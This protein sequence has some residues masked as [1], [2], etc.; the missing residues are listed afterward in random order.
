MPKPR[1]GRPHLRE[2]QR[3]Q[4]EIRFELPEDA[5]PPEHPARLLWEV[6]GR[7]DLGAF[8]AGVTS[9][10]D[11][12]G[13]PQLSPRMKLTLWLYAITCGIGSAREIAR[14]TRSDVA[15]RWVVGDLRVGHHTLSE[16]RAEHGEALE[17]LFTDVVA[18]LLH[19]GLLSLA[20]LAQDG[21]RVR[22]AAGAASFRSYGSLL[23]C[24]QQAALHLKAVL[25]EADDPALSHAQ[26]V[27][28]EQAARDFARRVEEAVEACKAQR[29]AH[30][31]RVARGST[32]D[33]EARVMK[34]ADGGFRPAYNLQYG[35]V[36]DRLGGPRTVV[37]VRVTNVGSD[38][39]SLA[40]MVEQVRARTG[41]LP[42]AVVADSNHAQHA[43][44]AALLALGVEPAVAAPRPRGG[45]PRGPHADRSEPVER[46][47]ALLASE[48]GK[49]LLRMRGSVCELANARQKGQQG[50]RQLLVRGLPKALNVALLG[51]LSANLLQ[52]AAALLG[53]APGVLLIYRL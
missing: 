23:E 3:S 9:T 41:A 5:L 25:A 13:R 40:P 27:R 17:R 28:R 51:A 33:A 24:R 26:R 37:G 7:F 48:R 42:G 36:G 2:P 16:L 6:L 22:A 10:P 8:S 44:L 45:R 47:R 29:E 14:R 32:T 53:S 49:R 50:L 34:M 38:L 21:T 30:P 39:G 19:R 46:W 20:V 15:F 1:T 4:A 18:Q 11:G 52:H 12:P 31:E 43:D 35:V